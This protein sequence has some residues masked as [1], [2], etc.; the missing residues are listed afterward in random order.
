MDYISE[1][2]LGE[3]HHQSHQRSAEASSRLALFAIR[4]KCCQADFNLMVWQKN[5]SEGGRKYYSV[6]KVVKNEVLISIQQIKSCI[7]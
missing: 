1:Y 3:P 7:K 6:G 2:A 5:K 4:P